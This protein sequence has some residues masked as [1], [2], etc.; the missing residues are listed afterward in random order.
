M[1][2]ARIEVW[3]HGDHRRARL[4]GILS[5]ANV[6]PNQASCNYAGLRVDDAGPP[7]AVNV[8]GHPRVYGFWPL[9]ARAATGEGQPL[10]EVS[11]AARMQAMC[12]ESGLHI[13]A[14]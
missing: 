10:T 2:V 9:L 1:L 5:L 11:I 3:P 12:D 6:T 13:P 4:V 8:D 14:R 7:S